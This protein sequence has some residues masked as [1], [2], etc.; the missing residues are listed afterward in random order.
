ME[1]TQSIQ[2]LLSSVSEINKKYEEIASI[3]GENF[4]IFK[5]LNLQSDEVRLHSRLLG[6]LLNP[7]GSHGKNEL[8]LELFLSTLN[9][10]SEYTQEEIKNATVI[11]EE[12]I[13]NIS[14]DYSKGGRIDLVIKF[15]GNKEIVIEN[16]IG[17]GDQFNQ[18]GRYHEQYHNA[19]I[20]Y[21]TPLE[22][23]PS[24]ESLGEKLKL[25]QVKCITYR[26]E[27]KKWIELC[28]EKTSNF[29]ML[30][31]T[32]TQ[33]IFLI[34]HITN[35]TMNEEMEKEIVKKIISSQ[36]MM[37]AAEII[38]NNFGGAKIEIMKSFGEKIRDK[39]P[40]LICDP[41]PGDD[42]DVEFH[43][44]NR[45]WSNVKIRIRLITNEYARISIR[46][47]N[48]FKELESFAALCEKLNS[49]FKN[50]NYKE[51]PNN[52][53]V[54]NIAKWDY[55]II[56]NSVNSDNDEFIKKI[57]ENIELYQNALANINGL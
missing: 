15:L 34:K 29:P 38:Y 16:K 37:N 26:N 20:L 8:F 24:K 32:I 41:F 31:E 22:K 11:V 49:K 46:Y 17:A 5:V 47:E 44:Y 30:R 28:H 10:N 13:G 18:L 6:E 21:L 33:Y 36:E 4:N 51:D 1:L 19:H 56:W 50:T 23:K 57:F 14:D 54:Y 9:L 3:T 12:N 43:F 7:H 25:E 48:D 35:Q 55:N 27:I 52:L 2:Y 40:N 42:N 53:F 45:K 39:F